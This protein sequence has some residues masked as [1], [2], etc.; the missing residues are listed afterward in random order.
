MA[1]LPDTDLEGAVIVAEKIRSAVE[2]N[3]VEAVG[4]VTLS[5]G[6]TVASSADAEMDIAVRRADTALYEAKRSGRNMVVTR[7]SDLG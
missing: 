7:Q 5:I 6:A 3:P 4:T 1:L 2:S